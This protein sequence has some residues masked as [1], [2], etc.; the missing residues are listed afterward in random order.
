MW[1]RSSFSNGS[2]GECVEVGGAG[3]A[4]VVR[5]SKDP[6]GPS[7]L[8]SPGAWADFTNRVASGRLASVRHGD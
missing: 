4:I 3:H 2:G 5:D 6:D 8:V 7:L 1:R